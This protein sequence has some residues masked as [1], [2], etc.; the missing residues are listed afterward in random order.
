MGGQVAPAPE[1]F[2][3]GGQ[4]PETALDRIV[5]S[6]LRTHG[7]QAAPPCSDAV[8]IR[9]VFLD[10]AGRLPEA[11]EARAFVTDRT[12]GKR[13]AL[14]DRLLSGEDFAVLSAMRWSEA[15]RVKSEF[16][17]NLWPN[18]VQAYHKWI[19]DAMRANVRYD[20]FATEL[21]TAS[22]SNF[23]SPPANFSRAVAE[24]T[25]AGV[26]SAVALTF[27]GRRWDSLDAGWRERME[28]VF[29]G[30]R[31]KPTAEWKEEVV[32]YAPLDSV[33]LFFPDGRPMGPCENGDPRPVFAR[34]L[35]DRGNAAFAQAAANRVWAWLFG[36]GVVQEPDDFRSGNPPAVPGL[37]EFLGRA[38][39]E[40]GYDLKTLHRLILTSATYQQSCVPVRAAP[41]AAA[42][43]ACYPVRQVEAEILADM[44]GQLT[45]TT[46]EY[47]SRIPEPFSF[48]P[49]GNHAVGIADG[50]VSSA[51]LDLFGRPPRDTGYFSER[52]RE[53]TEEQR[54]HLLNARQ[55][56]ERLSAGP[57]L[58]AIVKHAGNPSAV[59]DQ[60]Y[61]AT[62]SRAPDASELKIAVSYLSAQESPGPAAIDLAWALINTKEFL[63]HH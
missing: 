43:F 32:Y 40:S 31:Y 13:E 24:K 51:F 35:T 63:F 23:R 60:L 1:P 16:P 56:Q 15:L 54:R 33:R 5:R 41:E 2:A 58:R 45:G 49:Q 27:L 26:A 57:N 25:P 34:W 52:A 10:V 17:A 48:L 36:R 61:F 4:V 6:H 46:D 20:R 28:A 29:S 18:A 55:I 47:M 3:G 59:A 42:L 8:F 37:L 50:S 22:G 21:I 39:A 30:L 7:L 12:P 19:L 53:P 9:R 44:L 38:F 14:I 11:G 62:V